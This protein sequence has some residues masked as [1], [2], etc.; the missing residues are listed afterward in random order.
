MALRRYPFVDLIN[1]LYDPIV[2]SKLS[3]DVI[4]PD[5]DIDDHLYSSVYDRDTRQ[6]L[7]SPDENHLDPRVYLE[8]YYNDFDGIRVNIIY[9][10]NNKANYDNCPYWISS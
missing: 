10:F 8:T 4:L 2:Y 9:T 1:F 7:I 6:I 5:M 3:L